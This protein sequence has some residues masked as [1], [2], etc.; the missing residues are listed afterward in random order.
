MFGGCG[1]LNDGIADGADDDG[2]GGRDGNVGSGNAVVLAGYESTCVG[3]CDVA[4]AGDVFG[5]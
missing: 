3:A 2:G 1:G 5:T 4:Y